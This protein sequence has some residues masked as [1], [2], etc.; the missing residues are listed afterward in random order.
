MTVYTL[1]EVRAGLMLTPP[2]RL[3]VIGDPIS[4][5]KSPQMHNPALQHA[6]IDAQYVRVKVPVGQVAESFSILRDAGFWGINVTIPH[7]FEALAA[8]H[9]VDD[10]AKQ[11]GAVNTVRILPEGQLHGFNTD[12]PGYLNSVQEAFH[13]NLEGK[14]VLIIG[15][16]GGA[17]RAVAIQSALD[18]AS[19]LYLVNRT[20]EKVLPLVRE[21]E[22]LPGY[23]CSAVSTVWRHDALAAVLPE[24]DLIVNATSLGMKPEDEPLLPEA[25][26]QARHQVFDM[27]YVAKGSTWLSQAAASCGAAYVDGLTLLLHQGALSFQH[28]FSQP[29]PLEVMRTGL[30]GAVHS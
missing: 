14:R 9:E 20:A 21:I 22:Q 10:L 2:A 29:A 12:G 16:G 19:Q 7:K 6:G 28:W 3:A 24:V 4:H 26:L 18:G 17:G 1:D 5:S 25:A 30:A 27:V 15:T 13:C 11:L 8:V 23:H